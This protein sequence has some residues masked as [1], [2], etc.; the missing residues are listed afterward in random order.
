MRARSRAGRGNGRCLWREVTLATAI[1]VAGIGAGKLPA[2]ASAEVCPNAA[3]RSGSSASLP[4]CRVYEMVSPVKNEGGNV[5][6][7]QAGEESLGDAV[8]LTEFPFE[9]APDGNAVAYSADALSAGSGGHFADGYLATRAPS[10]GWAAVNLEP[11]GYVEVHYRGFSED[12]SVGILA[13]CEGPTTEE[14]R[15]TPEAPSGEYNMLYSHTNSDGGG[16]GYRALITVK[17]PKQPPVC[18]PAQGEAFFG[19]SPEGGRA[20]PPLYAGGTADLSHILFEA[21]DALTANA[22]PTGTDENNL[23]D[24][25]GGELR[26]VNVLPGESHGEPDAAFGSPWQGGG[27]PSDFSHIISAD[28]SR[29]FWTDL[30]TGD[31]Y[32]REN[33]TSTVPVSDGPAQFWTATPDGQYVF[34]TEGGKLWRF[35]VDSEAREGLAGEGAGVEGVIGVNETGEDGSY[36]YF[37]A[38]GILAG[39]ENANTEKAETGHYNLYVRHDDATTFIAALS[40]EDD[41]NR[42]G[43]PTEGASYGDWQPDLGHRTAEVTPDGHSVVFM[44]DQSLTGYDNIV[45]GEAMT[46]VYVYDAETEPH[47]SCASCDP[48]GAPPSVFFG[49]NERNSSFLPTSGSG[50]R[51]GSYTYL[52]R[53]ISDEG[54]RVFFD[55]VEPLV[56]QDT[57]G[58][59]DVYEWERDG[60]GS[61][62]DSGGCVYL[63]SGGTSTDSSSF[64]DASANGDD[65]FIVTRAQLVPQDRNED[66][67]LYD[68]R[69]GGVQPLSPPACSGTGCQGVPS[70]PPLFASPPSV[71]FN[72]VGNFE[73]PL[74]APAVKPKAKPLTRS[75]KLAK[76]L[77]ACRTK[78]KKKR[79]AC[80]AQAQKSYGV[81][82]KTKKSRKG[83]K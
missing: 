33:G 79:A 47:L 32:V 72:G 36:V 21:N 56:P 31:L 7:P 75:Q 43:A 51:A 62:Q 38:T 11:P 3:S 46:E 77:T 66:F 44:S 41:Q 14:P 13:T 45:N 74:P 19:S 52:P 27:N 26:L 16:S 15:L 60:A 22:T 6:T 76:A 58:L 10:G 29:I 71:T 65:A 81:K 34:Y 80:D 83:R 28:G 2:I 20:H 67:N 73:P 39:N 12:L 82:S 59:R 55:S 25:V 35:D 17:P 50:S 23:Y 57:N 49:H 4:D 40:A 53:W 61:C 70:A 8:T 24:L 78:P 48:S 5:F 18:E 54:D 68:A 30:K 42:V 37:V 1:V 69:V 9:A 64:I 63:L